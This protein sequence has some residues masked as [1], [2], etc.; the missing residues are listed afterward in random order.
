[1]PDPP[2]N[3]DDD[4]PSPTDEDGD[5]PIAVRTERLAER[6]ARDAATFEP[7]AAHPEPERALEYLTEGAGAAIGVYI[8]ARSGGEFY[9]FSKAEY[10]RL[11]RALNT[12]LRLY[13]ACYGVEID[14]SVTLRTAAEALI[15]T[16]DLRAVARTVTGVG[17][18]DPDEPL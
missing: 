9:R 5:V 12:W 2:A 3:A 8:D 1:M 17:E 10:E 7:P 6:A 4:P 13:A 16:N 11:E 15:D 18:P 14:P